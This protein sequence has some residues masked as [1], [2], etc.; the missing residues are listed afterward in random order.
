MA[1]S[2]PLGHD[3]GVPW[4]PAS[5]AAY[6]A[7]EPTV[8]VVAPLG[9]AHH[10][11]IKDAIAAAEP[12][13]RIL[14]RPGVYPEPLLIDKPVE[15]IADG[16][17]ADVVIETTAGGCVVMK[18]DYATIQGFTIRK[19]KG[20]DDYAVAIPRGRVVIDGCDI[21]SESRSC[22]AISGQGTAPVLRACK[23]HHGQQGGILVK[24]EAEAVIEDCDVYAN[25]MNGV[26]IWWGAHP[27]LRRC[28]IRDG[29][30]AGVS[31]HDNGRGI[32]EDCEIRGNA[33]CG[34]ATT[35][36][37]DPVIR[38]CRVHG[39]LQAGVLVIDGG[40][41]TLLDSDIWGNKFAGVQVTHRG[42]L[43]MRDSKIRDGLENGLYTRAGGGATVANCEFYG[44]AEPAIHIGP[45]SG[46][47]EVSG[48]RV[49]ETAT[50]LRMLQNPDPPAVPGS[51]AAKGR[52]AQVLADA[53]RTLKAMPDGKAPDRPKPGSRSS[54]SSEPNFRSLF[55]PDAE[56]KGVW[57]AKTQARQ[58]I[59]TALASADPD[60]A[61]RLARSASD[62]EARAEALT[63]VAVALADT[64]PERAGRLIQSVTDK[65]L[66]ATGLRR[67]AEAIANTDLEGAELL[68]K[69]IED[70]A[71][72]ARALGTLAVTVAKQDPDRAERLVRMITDAEIREE[73]LLDVTRQ[74]GIDPRHAER[75]AQLATAQKTK[76][77]ILYNLVMALAGTN[78]DRA[79]RVAESIS[80][81]VAGRKAA[82]LSQVAA[83]LSVRKR[84]HAE[85]LARK[86]DRLT[87][88]IADDYSRALA[89][90]GVATALAGVDPDNAERI[91]RWISESAAALAKTG[92]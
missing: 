27:T 45:G 39:Q 54:R 75:L 44:N 11:T 91:A 65:S 31:V 70:P 40:R 33:I 25:T 58:A 41:G 69:S 74:L 46:H 83:A 34:V 56:A 28:S 10:R 14:V 52:I 92:D 16:P 53:E 87:G 62:E 80:D 6:G 21:S 67:L 7:P 71:T 20:S 8:L 47:V 22:V 18:A 68:T 50:A 2:G 32:L 61:V 35:T 57:R 78:P 42:Q 1:I 73:K 23:I 81:Q 9:A 63:A 59:A 86:A 48:C 30:S 19:R 79:E 82:A 15:L 60:G 17:L 29:E 88:S 51:E 38:N 85:R 84:R 4:A 76:A 43:A 55:D 3:A 66:K 26:E 36:G 77:E 64:D 13:A 72:R 90:A 37:G 89:M 12:G 5:A 24:D 49:E